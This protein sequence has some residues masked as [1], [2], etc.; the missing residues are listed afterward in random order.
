MPP[1]PHNVQIPASID[2]KIITCPEMCWDRVPRLRDYLALTNTS[3]DAAGARPV[4][5]R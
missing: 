2:V 1:I 4:V 3:R 5:R